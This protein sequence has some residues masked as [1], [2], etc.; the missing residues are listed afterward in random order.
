MGILG[1]LKSAITPKPVEGTTFEEG[2]KWIGVK[3]IGSAAEK[4]T[5]EYWMTKTNLPMA[6]KKS[7]YLGTMEAGNNCVVVKLNGKAIGTLP[8]QF[9]RDALKVIKKQGGQARCAIKAASSTAKT[10]T[11]Y[12]RK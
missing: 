3:Y 9:A 4:D 10:Q 1:T 2:A 8:N 6:D 7:I 12:V 5:D 11:V